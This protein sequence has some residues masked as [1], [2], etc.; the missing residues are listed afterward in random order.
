VAGPICQDGRVKFVA[1]ISM[2]NPSYYLPLAQAA[3]DAGFD[4][5]SIPDSICYPQRT[6]SRYPNTPDGSREFLE[7]KPFIEPLV[8][9]AALSAV[10][11]RIRF[12]TGVLKL[13]IRNPVILAKEVTSLAVVTDGRLALGVGTSPWPD[14]Y[15]VVGLPWTGR[16]RRFDECI[17]IIRG[18][19]SGDY[20]E[21]HGNFYDFPA[22]KLNPVPVQPVPFLIGGH[23]DAYYRRAA[24]IGDGWVSAGMSLENL[25]AVIGRLE[26]LRHEH[27]RAGAPFEI[28]ASTADSATPDGIRRLEDLGVTH[29]SGGF[30]RFNPYGRE[31][32][33]E[34]L[35]EKIADLRRF[36]DSVIAKVR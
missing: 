1:G 31:Q 10:T 17:E 19:G 15:Q 5:I 14:D 13:P 20:F 23:S 28:H 34:S 24:A 3:E 25:A 30:G 35:S 22:I 16:R 6:D 12:L 27:G 18:L 21:Y 2:T 33:P 29:T 11:S 4:V 32:D 8:A 36:A 7:N 26:Q 9:I